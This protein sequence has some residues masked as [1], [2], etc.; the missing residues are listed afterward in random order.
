MEL[1]AFRLR[2]GIA[3]FGGHTDT[4]PSEDVEGTDEAMFPGR[5]ESRTS[6]LSSSTSTDDSIVTAEKKAE[7]GEEEETQGQ[8]CKK[9][10]ATTSSF[11]SSVKRLFLDIRL[12]FW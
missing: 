8:E 6:D 2:M 4:S 1:A 9:F 5:K 7:D 12:F 10:Q 11:R 3:N